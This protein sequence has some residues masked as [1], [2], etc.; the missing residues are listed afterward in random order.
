[1]GRHHQ[2]GLGL[3]PDHSRFG[4]AGRHLFRDHQIVPQ[5]IRNNLSV[6]KSLRLDEGIFYYH[7]EIKSSGTIHEIV[8]MDIKASKKP[9]Q[10][11]AR[12]VTATAGRAIA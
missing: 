9:R 11:S 2:P 5:V 1:L 12:V 3:D 7:N 8:Y 6:G 10:K 4:P